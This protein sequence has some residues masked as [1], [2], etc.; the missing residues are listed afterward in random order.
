MVKIKYV[1]LK[2][3]GERAFMEH[4]GIEWFHGSEHE[5]SDENAGMM[6]RHPDVFERVSGAEVALA[7]RAIRKI[8]A[9]DDMHADDE[10]VDREDA[11]KKAAQAAQSAAADAK[12]AKA[13]ATPTDDG[14]DTL[15]DAGVRAYAKKHKLKVM[16]I[17]LLKGKK[18]RDKVRE[19]AK[20]K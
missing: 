19:A 4:T 9:P 20:A 16:G 3:D 18:L 12:V 1:G 7:P 13:E 2:Q 11:A 5:V 14:L 10:A 17:G 8:V 15:D 6:L